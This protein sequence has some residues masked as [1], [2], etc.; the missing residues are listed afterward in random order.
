MSKFSSFKKYLVK[1]LVTIGALNAFCLAISGIF[2]FLALAAI[3]LGHVVTDSGIG[4]FSRGYVKLTFTTNWSIT[5]LT[6][7]SLCM[8]V[9]FVIYKTYSKEEIYKKSS[10]R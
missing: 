10:I 8:F 3:A 6:L 2:F 7:A 9:L 4:S 1:A 5:T